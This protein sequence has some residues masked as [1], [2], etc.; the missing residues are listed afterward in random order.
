MC[1]AA[2]R[3]VESS[4]GPNI[5]KGRYF[6]FPQKKTPDDMMDVDEEVHS[7]S[8]SDSMDEVL[9][10]ALRPTWFNG[11]QEVFPICQSLNPDLHGKQRFFLIVFPRIVLDFA[12]F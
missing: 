8:Q 12:R 7:S 5:R 2:G 10:R 3:L 1:T 9:A 11:F 6:A 4:L